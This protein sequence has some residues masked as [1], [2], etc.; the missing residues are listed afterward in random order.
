MNFLRI[1]NLTKI[2]YIDDSVQLSESSISV[3]KL[4]T[5]K[6]LINNIRRNKYAPNYI[7]T[8]KHTGQ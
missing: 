8:L 1:L 6:T 3:S 7:Q 5:K 2:I 4:N